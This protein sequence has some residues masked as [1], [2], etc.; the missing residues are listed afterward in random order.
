MN[1][2]QKLRELKKTLWKNGIIISVILVIIVCVIIALTNGSMIWIELI[3]LALDVLL[4]FGIYVT[5]TFL[6]AFADIVEY[7]YQTSTEV[8]RIA[9]Y[10]PYLKAINFN[11]KGLSSYFPTESK[12]NQQ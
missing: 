1:S 11:T 10:S 7:T 5:A 3:I 4:L 9:A 6:E 8:Q 12:N 2:S